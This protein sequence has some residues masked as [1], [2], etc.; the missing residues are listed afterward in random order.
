MDSILSF[1]EIVSK[2]VCK[3]GLRL[4]VIPSTSLAYRCLLASSLMP[5][6]RICGIL[7]FYRNE[8][9]QSSDPELELTLTKLNRIVFT[10]CIALWKG[11][12][13]QETTLRIPECASKSLCDK[14]SAK[15]SPNQ[16]LI[17]P[18]N[19]ALVSFTWQFLQE[20]PGNN[21]NLSTLS[22]DQNAF[23]QFI[24]YVGKKGMVGLE[25]FLFSSIKHWKPRPAS[26]HCNFIEK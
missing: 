5:L 1:F 14:S 24:Q 15:S 21:L 4:I 23:R 11:Q 2:F 10:F 26:R 25:S 20:C 22:T 18:T 17:V 12:L 19:Q 3:Y 9:Q 6:E 8:F 7:V 13:F 16:C